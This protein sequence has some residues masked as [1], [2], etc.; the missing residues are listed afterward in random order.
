MKSTKIVT[1]LEFF[2]A[3]IGMGITMFMVGLRLYKSP[4]KSIKGI[5]L[6]MDNF[7]E[8]TKNKKVRKF[9]KSEGK[10]AWDPYHPVWPSKKFNQSVKQHLEEVFP[11]SA[12]ASPLRILF[13]SITKK[14]PL[15]CEHC[16]EGDSLNSPNALTQEELTQHIEHYVNTG[17]SHII[18]TGGEPLNRFEDLV[19]IVESMS[20]KTEQ[21]L[22]S[23][24]FGLTE[25]KAMALKNAGLRGIN[26]GLDSYIE[27]NHNSF[28]GNSKSFDWVKKAIKNCQKTGLVVSLN[29]CPTKEFLASYSLDEYIEFARSLGVTMISMIEPRAIGNYANKDVELNDEEKDQLRNAFFKYNYNKKYSHYPIVLYPGIL[30]PYNKCGGGKAYIYLEYDGNVYP[31]GFCRTKKHNP[32]RSIHKNTTLP[33]INKKVA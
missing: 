25:A 3:R 30:K 19:T 8:A 5:R 12:S 32:C 11:S 28:R 23:S 13:A 7:R 17:A 21:W 16:S 26:F 33:P 20:S 27:A 4:A 10:Y 24:G 29:L 6:F 18:Y 9:Y 1:G 31:C 22:N 15:Q 14:C 2:L